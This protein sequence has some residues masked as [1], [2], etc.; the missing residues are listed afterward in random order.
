VKTLVLV[1]LAFSGTATCLFAV[2]TVAFRRGMKTR[3]AGAGAY[4]VASLLKPVK[5]IDDGL[6]ANLESFYRLDYPA[7]EI[8]FAVDDLQDPCV[9][10]LKGLQAAYPGIP[11]R[12]VATGRP[13]HENPKVH[14][15]ARLESKARGALY[16]TTD[17]NIR[18]EPGTLRRLADEYLAHD[19]KLVFSPI[20]SSSSRTFGSLM[21]NSSINFFTSGGII[22]SWF[23]GRWP[24][25]VGKSF[26]IEREALASLGGFGAFRNYLAEDFLLAEAFRKSGYRVATNCTWV[27]SVSRTASARSF[28]KRMSRWAKLRFHLR[29]PAYL[30]EVLLNPVVI[31]L[32]APAVFGRRGWTVLAV[33]AAAKIAL[34]YLNFLFVNTED[35]RR[36]R[37]HLLFPAAVVAKDLLFLA[38]YFTPFFS[39]RV[40]WRGGRIS[41]GKNTLI[42]APE[43]ADHLVYEGA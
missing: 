11:T 1:L 14:K 20:R 39:R 17:S 42:L 7:Y 34:E 23:L 38:V 6:A 41:I 43:N 22:A 36:P 15:L 31:A 13:R 5:N 2:L 19:A 35:R 28:F 40:E 4:P 18:V 26:L 27:T 12:I 25:P 16:W 33:M 37:N 29:P 3:G 30:L 10:L 9:S 32:A 8:L 24:V 21:E